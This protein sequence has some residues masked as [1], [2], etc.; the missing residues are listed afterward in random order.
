MTW[1][2][3]NWI[4]LLFM[5]GAFLLVF[6]GG[7]GCG[8]GHGHHHNHRRDD[9][10]TDNEPSRKETVQGSADSERKQHAHG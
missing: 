10:T 4:W 6:R 9:R 2:G 1:I 5:L 8:M 7:M 3:S